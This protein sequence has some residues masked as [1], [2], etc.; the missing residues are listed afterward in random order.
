MSAQRSGDREHPESTQG[1]A[2][3]EQQLRSILQLFIC[4][5]IEKRVV[6]FDLSKLN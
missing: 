2:S 3:S 4:P 5:K 6:G 1:I